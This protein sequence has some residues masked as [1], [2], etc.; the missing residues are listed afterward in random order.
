L[1]T[2][3]SERQVVVDRLTQIN[4]E[5]APLRSRM[6]AI[7]ESA[8]EATREAIR[9]RVAEV[10]DMLQAIIERDEQDRQSLEESKAQVGR[11]LAKVRTAPAAIHAYKT[12]P[13]AA[14]GRAYAPTAARFTDARG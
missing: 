4:G 2:V 11:E 1:L 10:Q 14:A 7:T 5:L 3:L 6:A 9:S 8:S 12:S 13:P